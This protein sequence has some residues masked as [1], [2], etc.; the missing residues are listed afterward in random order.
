MYH[1]TY[2]KEIETLTDRDDFINTI[3]Q[4]PYKNWFGSL[5]VSEKDIWIYCRFGFNTHINQANIFL[6]HLKNLR[7]KNTFTIYII[8][9]IIYIHTLY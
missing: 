7:D 1:K 8:A 9:N 3:T 6:S 5:Q 2:G 4:F